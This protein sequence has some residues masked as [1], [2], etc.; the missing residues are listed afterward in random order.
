MYRHNCGCGCAP[1]PAASCPA[2]VTYAPVAT[3]YAGYQHTPFEFTVRTCGCG[4]G[5][6]NSGYGQFNSGYGYRNSFYR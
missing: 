3:T 5:T 6:L 4:D 1:A 2:Y